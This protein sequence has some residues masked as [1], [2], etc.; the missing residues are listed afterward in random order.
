MVFSMLS[1]TNIF[2]DLADSRSRA[3]WAVPTDFGDLNHVDAGNKRNVSLLKS[4]LVALLPALPIPP[5]NR[6][7]Y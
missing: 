1:L 6:L 7:Q 5:P 3:K 4:A 2:D